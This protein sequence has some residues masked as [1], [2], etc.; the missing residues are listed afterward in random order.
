MICLNCGLC[1]I[2][3]DVVIIS[4]DYAREG[5]IFKKLP[6]DAFI[7]KRGRTPCPHLYWEVEESRCMIHNY[8]WYEQTP[9]YDFT[10]VESKSSDFCRI[11]QYSI[12][13]DGP[14]HWRLYSEIIH[15]EVLSPK[16]L[17]ESFS[18][19]IRKGLKN[20]KDT[21]RQILPPEA[22]RQMSGGITR[23]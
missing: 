9:C 20:A 7:I 4:P 2:Q 17:T 8:S 19:S 3:F 12:K 23:G 13:T 15:N 6:E 10:Q 18:A 14:E 5:I 21:T 16:E 11:G 1:C 22:L